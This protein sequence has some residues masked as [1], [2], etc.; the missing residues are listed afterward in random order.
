MP[1]PWSTGNVL[2][3]ADLNAAIAAALG[4]GATAVATHASST[5]HDGRYYTKTEI[6]V[7]GFYAFVRAASEGVW[8]TIPSDTPPAPAQEYVFVSKIG[9]GPTAV[10]DPTLPKPIVTNP[11]IGIHTWIAAP[12][13]DPNA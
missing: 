7:V 12:D 13:V 9:T 6:Q 3:A 1:Y 5:D 4:D 10:W 11:N 2:T 8:Q